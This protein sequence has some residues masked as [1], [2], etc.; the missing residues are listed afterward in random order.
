MKKIIFAIIILCVIL[1]AAFSEVT[2]KTTKRYP[3]RKVEFEDGLGDGIIAGAPKE[4]TY[5]NG[6]GVEIAKE[7]F[8]EKADSVILGK[9]PN[10]IV[11]E[12]YSNEELSKEAIDEGRNK[13]PPKGFELIHLKAELNYKD[14]KITGLVK[15]YYVSGKIRQELNVKDDKPNGVGKTFYESG[16]LETETMWKDG[17]LD[18]Q[19][20]SYY[21]NGKLEGTEYYTA[22]K[23]NGVVKEY[24]RSGVLKSELNYK[25]DKK[26][27]LFKLYYEN[28][29]IKQEAM[30]DNNKLNGKYKKYDK[31]G[32]INA[33]G[34]N[35]D[36]KMNGFCE[37]Y[38]NGKL[39]QVD[40][41]VDNKRNGL[42]IKYY[43]IGNIAGE[44]NFKD[45]KLNGIAKGYYDNNE[46]SFI[47][48]YKKGV[49]INS[50]KYDLIGGLILNQDYPYD[51]AI[52]DENIEQS[53]SDTIATALYNTKS[54]SVLERSKIREV[55]REQQLQLTGC[56]E[57][58]RA[59]KI[60][61]ILNVRYIVVGSISKVAGEI[62]INLRIV[63]VEN[64]EISSAETG[65]YKQEKDIIDG[66]KSIIISMVKN[67]RE[68]NHKSKEPIP[69]AVMEISIK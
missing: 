60:G 32:V 55:F 27:G 10:G 54:F 26:F 28:G 6:K 67:F 58:E 17:K 61:K 62:V 63:N 45:D 24:Y 8:N 39:S 25:D 23:F 36:D 48:T 18:G 41:Y 44:W 43:D 1:G 21:E 46:I 64:S 47:D 29:N 56:T 20:K 9:I 35:V 69:L 51:P 14:N 33:I 40:T 13:I 2:R 52:T 22:G 19:G 65:K 68:L 57:E 5:Y 42:T 31:N 38:E 16:K 7:I 59:V 34:N 50:K 53:I 4:I 66:L 11:K 49:K 37:L 15:H 12:Y 3:E 30:Y